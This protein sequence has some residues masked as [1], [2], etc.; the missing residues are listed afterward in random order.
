L[1]CYKEDPVLFVWDVGGLFH[2]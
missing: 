2:V 1:G